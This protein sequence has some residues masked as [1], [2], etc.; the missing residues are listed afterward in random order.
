VDWRGL[1]AVTKSL[2]EEGTVEKIDS[3]YYP[4]ED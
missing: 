2:L 4:V 1:I 3:L